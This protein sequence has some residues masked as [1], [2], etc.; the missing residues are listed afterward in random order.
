[1]ALLLVGLE[2]V[3]QEAV[4]VALVGVVDL[5]AELEQ[6]DPEIG[7][8]DDGPA[9]PAAG[10][11][12]RRAADEA[13]GAV[14]DDGVRLVA[15]DHAD[16]EEAG[17]FAVH[18]VV[19]DAALAVAMVLR[20]LHHADLRV[21]ESRYQIFQPVGPHHIVGIDDADDLRVARGVGEREPQR[22]GLVA[23]DI[24]VMDELEALAE[25]TAMLLDR[26]ARTPD[27]ACC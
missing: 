10:S 13:H 23:F 9:R 22:A 20:R 11:L 7:V 8:F 18:R 2:R 1:M 17:V 21:G 12:D 15:L 26:A 25:R 14:H 4:A 24:V 27:R 5:P 6:G 19:H 3:G 16:V